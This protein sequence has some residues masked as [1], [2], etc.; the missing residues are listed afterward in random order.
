MTYD[1]EYALESHRSTITIAIEAVRALL[2]ANGGAV[3]AILTFLGDVSD[4]PESVAPARVASALVL[5]SF[6]LAGAIAA[7]ILGYFAQANFTH[8]KISEDE[9]PVT[10]AEKRAKRLGVPLLTLAVIATIFSLSRF[11]LGV[12]E[13][14]QSLLQPAASTR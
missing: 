5:F 7:L 6:G 11:V 1:D 10:A 12:Q 3:V 2:L 9:K 4:K 14:A 8:G 13:V